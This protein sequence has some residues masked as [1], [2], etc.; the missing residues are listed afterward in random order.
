[1]GE[2][3]P[4][5]GNRG[6]RLGLTRPLV[7]QAQV[8]AVIG[9]ALDAAAEGLDPRP[10]LLVPIVAAAEE[11]RALVPS[12]A[13]VA[14]DVYAERGARVAYRVGV[15]LALPRACL[16]AHEL[17]RSAAFFTSGTNDR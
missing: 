8:R 13:A 3:N 14:E 6:A 1:M 15:I 2:K 9:A 7:Y 5:L 11:L 10:E 16:V 12:L 4:L 17:A